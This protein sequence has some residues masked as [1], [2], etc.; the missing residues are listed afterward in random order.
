MHAMNPLEQ[1]GALGNADTGGAWLSC[2]Y[3]VLDYVPQHGKLSSTSSFDYRLLVSTR[4]MG[5]LHLD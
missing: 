4:R 2:C 5:T 3:K 1:R